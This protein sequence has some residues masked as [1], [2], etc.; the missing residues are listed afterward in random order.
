IGSVSRI[1]APPETNDSSWTTAII[2]T[3]SGRPLRAMVFMSKQQ[4]FEFLL[5]P[6]DYLLQANGNGVYGANRFF[7]LTDDMQTLQLHLDLS[8]DRLTILTGKPAPE[9]REIKAWKNGGLTTLEK[10]R[11]KW[12]VLDFWG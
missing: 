2:N 8:P 10:L 5:P 9:L 7:R 6:G 11:G 3:I 12:V 4:A 1:G